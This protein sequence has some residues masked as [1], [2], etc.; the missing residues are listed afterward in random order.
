MAYSPVESLTWLNRRL[1]RSHGADRP[2]LRALPISL[3][4]PVS[5]H[6]RSTQCSGPEGVAPSIS[7]PSTSVPISEADTDYPRDLAEGRTWEDASP[8]PTSPAKERDDS[9]RRDSGDLLTGCTLLVILFVTRHA[10]PLSPVGSV[11]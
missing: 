9:G 11:T 10:A 1:D 7:A 5:R 6:A 4:E 3:V 2:L 8:C